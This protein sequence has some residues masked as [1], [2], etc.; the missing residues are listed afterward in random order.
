M[1][2]ILSM[3]KE[4]R[5]REVMITVFKILNPFDNVDNNSLK[6]AKED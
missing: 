6:L 1:A 2:I 3:L 4:R 5:K